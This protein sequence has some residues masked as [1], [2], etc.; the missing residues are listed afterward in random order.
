MQQFILWSHIHITSSFFLSAAHPAWITR[1]FTAA[2]A[3]ARRRAWLHRKRRHRLAPRFG[4]P[5]QGPFAAEIAYDQIRVIAR[6]TNCPAAFRNDETRNIRKVERKGAASATSAL[7]I[8]ICVATILLDNQHKPTIHSASEAGSGTVPR[9][10]P[11]P[12]PGDSP[13]YVRPLE[14]VVQRSA[15]EPLETPRESGPRSA[16][17]LADFTTP[18]NRS[19][20]SSESGRGER[21]LAPTCSVPLYSE[22]RRE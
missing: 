22:T 19:L 17:H 18:L 5:M 14:C 16:G 8:L 9:P 11:L 3:A 1:W 12:A 20:V 2:L 6:R 7:R 4:D 21:S 15:M 13:K 10:A